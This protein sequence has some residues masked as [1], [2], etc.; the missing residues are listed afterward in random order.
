M[1]LWK[2][3]LDQSA[4]FITRFICTLPHLP[5]FPSISRSFLRY[6]NKN[7]QKFLPFPQHHK[8]LNSAGFASKLISQRA[9]RLTAA[10][11]YSYKFYQRFPRL[12]LLHIAP[13]SLTIAFAGLTTVKCEDVICTCTVCAKKISSD[14]PSSSSNNTCGCQVQNSSKAIAKSNSEYTPLVADWLEPKDMSNGALIKQ[15]CILTV[16]SVT[17]ILSQVVI[18]VEDYHG[19][20]RALLGVMIEMLEECRSCSAGQIE[21]LECKLVVVRSKLDEMKKNISTLEAYMV[22]VEKLASAAAET[23]F[24]GNAEYQSYAMMERLDSAMTY[25]KNI[26]AESKQVERD[27]LELQSMLI[28]ESGKSLK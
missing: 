10:S 8:I 27:M 3:G 7:Y 1:N 25:I 13:F 11:F 2:K 16:D 6:L 9:T 24:L 20:Y 12:R 21:L 28:I 15:A 14:A 5:N 17:R 4:N 18:A 22:T 26:K 19:Q 23:A